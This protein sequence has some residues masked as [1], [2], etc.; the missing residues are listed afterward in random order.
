M[1]LL[2]PNFRPESWA[3]NAG[4][5][6]SGVQISKNFRGGMPPDPPSIASIS[7]MIQS[8]LRLDPPL[9]YTHG[10]TMKFA[11]KF[12]NCVIFVSLFK[13]IFYSNRLMTKFGATWAT[14]VIIECH[15]SFASITIR[16][17]LT[18][19]TVKWLLYEVA[20]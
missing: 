3:Q 18:V 6:I 8:D 11:Q 9:P 2:R 12:Y 5:G 20:K 17:V 7:A 10:N 4:N 15:F 13:I 1:T 19:I 14:K 16:H